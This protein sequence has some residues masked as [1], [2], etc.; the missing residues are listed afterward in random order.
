MLEVRFIN[1]SSVL[2]VGRVKRVKQGRDVW[3]VRILKTGGLETAHGSDIL[4][5]I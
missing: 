2:K 4:V 5:N 3:G 1:I